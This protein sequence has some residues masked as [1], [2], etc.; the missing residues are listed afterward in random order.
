MDVE[1]PEIC[2]THLKKH[3][4][5]ALDMNVEDDKQHLDQQLLDDYAQRFCQHVTSS[6][7]RALAALFGWA[8]IEEDYAVGPVECLVCF[9]ILEFMVI[10]C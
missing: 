6:H 10:L 8:P 7:T 4:M 1:T 3:V 5:R 2:P 9:L